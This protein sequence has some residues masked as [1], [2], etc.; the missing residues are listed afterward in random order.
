[1]NKT[2]LKSRNIKTGHQWLQIGMAQLKSPRAISFFSHVR[3]SLGE[4]LEKP[5]TQKTKNVSGLTQSA[6]L[7]TDF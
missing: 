3:T 1:M 6:R 5:S 7:P 2:V 4:S